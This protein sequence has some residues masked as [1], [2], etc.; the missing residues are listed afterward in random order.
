MWFFIPLFA[1]YLS[2]PFL[3]AMLDHLS[4]RHLYLL[5]S[6]SAIF[7]SLL[8]Y[9]LGI[10]HINKMNYEL[11]PMM[12]NLLMYGVLGYLIA[13][14]DFFV[15]YKKIVYGL[16]VLS[17]VISFVFLYHGLVSGFSSKLYTT[18]VSP[19][20]LVISVGIFILFKEVKWE[21][22]LSKLRIPPEMVTYI[23][24]CSFGVYLVH[25]LFRRVSDHY[26][27][28]ITNPYY[29]AFLLYLI[30]LIFVIFLKKIPLIK[31]IVP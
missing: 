16:S 2:V 22:V 9:M 14:K 24:Q 4:R 17:F 7:N 27:W 28:I 11:F 8:P 10:L 18:Y 6:F 1:L 31:R 23:S 21:S 13:R 3:K 19:F 29:G 25:Q 20:L 30:S 26:Q 5:V 12:S 15:G